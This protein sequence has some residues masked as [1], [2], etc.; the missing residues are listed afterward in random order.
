[1]AVL[2]PAWLT[3]AGCENRPPP[4]GGVEPETV[5]RPSA[6]PAPLPGGAGADSGFLGVVLAGEWADLA[7]RIDGRVQ[8]V[9]VRPG[10]PVRRGQPIARLDATAA[11]HELAIARAALDE[12]ARRF[13]RRTHLARTTP[14]AVTVEELDG[15]RREL[16]QARA[17]VAEV[18][19]ARG[20]ASLRAPFDGTV[21]ERYLSPGALAGPGRPVVRVVGQGLPRVRFAIPEERAGAVALGSGVRIQLP[22]AGRPFTGEVTGLSPEVDASSRMVYAAATVDGE[23]AGDPRLTTGVIARVFPRATWRR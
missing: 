11:R 2:L 5:P 9:L 15:V 21:A 20:E 13:A 17:R 22:S 7:P 18:A 16:L 23:A 1:M 19:Q 4:G 6:G 12:A 14:D 10:D 8:A 3:L